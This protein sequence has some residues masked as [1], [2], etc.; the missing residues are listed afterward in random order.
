VKERTPP[1]ET[2]G[3]GWQPVV[4]PNGAGA[5]VDDVQPGAAAPEHPEAAGGAVHVPSWPLPATIERSTT[6]KPASTATVPMMT[7]IIEALPTFAPAAP[8]WPVLHPDPF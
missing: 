6:A 3:L 1:V 5:G 8:Q 4:D 7:R 2:T